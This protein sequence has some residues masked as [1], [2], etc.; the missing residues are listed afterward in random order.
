LDQELAKQNRKLPE[1]INRQI[2]KNR[3]RLRLSVQDLLT[4]Q[5]GPLAAKQLGL[6]DPQPAGPSSP[7]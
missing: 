7:P 3:D 2:D 4:T 1:K 6:G 5:W